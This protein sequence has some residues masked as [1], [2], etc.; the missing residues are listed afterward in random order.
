MTGEHAKVVCASLEAVLG[1]GWSRDVFNALRDT[2][3]GAKSLN[4]AAVAAVDALGCVDVDAA[5]FGDG[6][7]GDVGG[8]RARS[9]L[10]GK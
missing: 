1:H 4:A 6:L 9:G 2:R 5:Y 8:A 3:R 7:V 10:L